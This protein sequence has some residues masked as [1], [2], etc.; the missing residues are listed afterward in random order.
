MGALSFFLR[1]W[2]RLGT[3]AVR[4]GMLPNRIDILSMHHLI[5]SDERTPFQRNVRTVTVSPAA[6]R[7][8]DEAMAV[9]GGSLIKLLSHRSASG[10]LNKYSRG[11]FLVEFRTR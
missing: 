3:S 11:G 7:G 6:D 9:N 10:K 4:K 2:L 1:L 8:R 5:M